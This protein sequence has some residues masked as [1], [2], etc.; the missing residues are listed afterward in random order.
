[1]IKKRQRREAAAF[2]LLFSLVATVA[3]FQVLGFTIPSPMVVY[4]D[5]IENVLHIGYSPG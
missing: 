2:I 1:V 4:G 3:I 5:F